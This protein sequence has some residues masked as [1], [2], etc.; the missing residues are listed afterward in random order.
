MDI[1]GNRQNNGKLF[2]FAYSYS[3]RDTKTNFPS[4]VGSI[5]DIH[6]N[7]FID[8]YILSE[9]FQIF[10]FVLFYILFSTIFTLSLFYNYSN[11]MLVL[12]GIILS[13]FLVFL[14]FK[15]FIK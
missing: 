1:Y 4:Q 9:K 15:F 8:H 11:I 13:I 6:S 10:Y 5:K 14:L 7:N 2:T 3:Y 12:G